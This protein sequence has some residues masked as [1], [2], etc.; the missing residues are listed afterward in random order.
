[1][2]LKEDEAVSTYAKFSVAEALDKFG[3]F[4]G[5]LFLTIINNDKIVACTLIFIKCNGI[6]LA[7]VRGTLKI[8]LVKYGLIQD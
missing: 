3:I 1:M 5:E 2:F 6:H 4:F 7:N 8:P